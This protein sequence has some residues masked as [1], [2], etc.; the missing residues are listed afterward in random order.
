M[1]GSK[2]QLLSSLMDVADRHGSFFLVDGMSDDEF[3]ELQVEALH[4]VEK[5]VGR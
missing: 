5:A 4:R 3:A 2:R 1:E